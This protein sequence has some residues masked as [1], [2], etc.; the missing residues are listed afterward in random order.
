MTDNTKIQNTQKRRVVKITTMGQHNRLHCYL[1][2]IISYKTSTRITHQR[3]SYLHRVVE[4]SFT[5]QSSS[6]TKL[7][8]RS[9]PTSKNNALQIY[10]W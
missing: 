1:N 8:Y 9:H 2:G 7:L 6:V 10:K 5:V 4:K 3:H